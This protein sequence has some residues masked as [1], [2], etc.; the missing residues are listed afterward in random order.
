MKT[1]GRNEQDCVK[2][3]TLMSNCVPFIYSYALKSYMGADEEAL[4]EN[5]K[6]LYYIC[7]KLN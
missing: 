1:E 2:E 3:I 6:L 7:L 5:G 4:Q